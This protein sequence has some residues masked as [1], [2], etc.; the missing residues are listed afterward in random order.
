MPHPKRFRNSFRSYLTSIIT[1]FLIA[2]FISAFAFFST[3]SKKPVSPVTPSFQKI[4]DALPDAYKKNL[5][6]IIG[7]MEIMKKHYINHVSEQEFMIDMREGFVQ[8]VGPYCFYFPKDEG[9]INAQGYTGF[10]FT[11][12]N[13]HYTV[14]Y[15]ASNSPAQKSHIREGDEILAIDGKNIRYTKDGFNDYFNS[16]SPTATFTILRR[17]VTFN[18]TVLKKKISIPDVAAKQIGPW[19]YIKIYRFSSG[20]GLAILPCFAQCLGSQ[21]YILDLRDNPGGDSI[22]AKRITS[23]FLPLGKV[24][25][26]EKDRSGKQD[27]WIS[28]AHYRI[29]KAPVVVLMNHNSASCSEI[30]AA[31]LQYYHRAKI[32]GELSVGKGVEQQVFNLTG[33]LKGDSLWLPMWRLFLPD[34][35]TWDRRGVIPD[36]E[37]SDIHPV[38]GFVQDSP[39]NDPV[40]RKAVQVLE[41]ETENSHKK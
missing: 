28:Q 22:E 20:A 32:V 16:S 15:V 33:N 30:V 25:I 27:A 17:G 23:H 1:F 11:E 12:H 13:G 5:I 35:T 31:V 6:H 8:D 38:L 7:L 36:Y 4:L 24:M 40:L 3:L 14:T 39:R 9:S 34:N 26:L 21:G 18:I 37:V 2:S 29:T 41:R 10:R 19:A